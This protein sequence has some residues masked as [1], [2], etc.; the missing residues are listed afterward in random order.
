MVTAALH[1][2]LGAAAKLGGNA[3][4]FLDRLVAALTKPK[5]AKVPRQTDTV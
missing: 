4:A 3:A 1:P 5:G 2:A